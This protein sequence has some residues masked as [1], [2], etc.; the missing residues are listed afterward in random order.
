MVRRLVRSFKVTTHFQIFPVV[1]KR[2]NASAPRSIAEYDF[3]SASSTGTPIVRESGINGTSY[4]ITEDLAPGTYRFWVRAIGTDGT[5]SPWSLNSQSFISVLSVS[6]PVLNAVADGTD[7]TPT[8]T[9]QAADGAVRYEVYVSRRLT[10]GTAVVRVNDITSTSFTPSVSLQ[11]DDYRVWVRAISA[12]NDLSR[13]SVHADFTISVA[14]LQ[15]V[16]DS[17]SV[18]LASLDG[19]QTDWSEDE[20]TVTQPPAAKPAEHAASPFHNGWQLVTME[21]DLQPDD[22]A[23]PVIDSDAEDT[24]L[25]D[26]LM[27]QWDD[28]IWAEESIVAS[29]EETVEKEEAS[30]GWLAGLAAL[31]PSVFRRRRRREDQQKS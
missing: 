9:W 14:S 28:A 24:E 21:E 12:D 20:V 5:L 2:W 11:P 17:S 13:W 19:A 30:A 27:A 1:F 31:T 29:S 22:V 8:I 18:L 4:T 10:P 7:T 15:D 6:R 23:V 16:E 3:A 26:D 25:S